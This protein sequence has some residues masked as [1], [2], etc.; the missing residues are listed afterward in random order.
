ML[1]LEALK[2]IVAKQNSQAA[3]DTYLKTSWILSPVAVL[4]T[5]LDMSVTATIGTLVRWVV[6][7][8]WTSGLS[9]PP[10]LGIRSQIGAEWC[11]CA[12]VVLLFGGC[13]VIAL[14]E[15]SDYQ[16]AALRSQMMARARLMATSWLLL[17]VAAQ[18]GS[19]RELVEGIHTT[20]RHWMPSGLSVLAASGAVVV[21]FLVSMMSL[22]RIDGLWLA[23]RALWGLVCVP[24]L[25]FG[26]FLGTLVMAS[27]M[28]TVGFI[29]WPMTYV[30]K[31][32]TWMLSLTPESIQR[33]RIRATEGVVLPS[34]A[35]IVPLQSGHV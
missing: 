16:D 34:G 17:V 1:G 13:I 2:M 10:I 9:A 32:G 15:R 12:A 4:A 27:L 30:I 6:P 8:Q 22:R 28:T 24:M 19:L 18:L 33:A 29:L 20:T 23:G 26:R 14:E 5:A 25:G 7:T 35:E 31:A 3:D 21:V 11:A